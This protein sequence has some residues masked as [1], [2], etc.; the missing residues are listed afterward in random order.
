MECLDWIDS[1]AKEIG[2]V[3]TVVVEGDRLKGYNTDAAGF[4]DPLFKRFTTLRDARVAIIGAG[5][6]ARAAIWSLQRQNANVTLFARNPRKAQSLADLF[7]ISC[8][9]LTEASFAGYDLVI[10]TTPLGSGAYMD[11]S[12]VTREQLSGSRCVYDLIYNPR[13]TILLREA[14]EAGCETLGGLE[15]LVAQ[16]GLQFELWTGRKFSDEF[17]RRNTDFM[18]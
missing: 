16:A 5:G 13:E 14:H 10:N 17:S 2:A 12:P 18:Y 15:M 1:D 4:I 3:N 9:S 6:A 11:Q 8:E 7:G